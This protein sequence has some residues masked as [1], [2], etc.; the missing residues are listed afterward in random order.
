MRRRKQ[1]QIIKRKVNPPMP[2]RAMRST[3]AQ[4]ANTAFINGSHVSITFGPPLNAELKLLN[5]SKSSLSLL[6]IACS[7]QKTRS[8]LSCSAIQNQGDRSIVSV[9]GFGVSMLLCVPLPLYSLPHVSKCCMWLLGFDAYL[10]M[11]CLLSRHGVLVS[12]YICL[13]VYVCCIFFSISVVFGSQLSLQS[14]SKLSLQSLAEIIVFSVFATSRAWYPPSLRRK[15]LMM[16]WSLRVTM[17]KPETI[18]LT[19]SM[20][21]GNVKML[22]THAL[23]LVIRKSLVTMTRTL[24]RRVEII[25]NSTLL[26]N[27]KTTR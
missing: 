1:I 15:K 21:K 27:S 24:L 16:R 25:M 9:F 26:T 7:T 13:F 22:T 18:V 19:M 8:I 3:N 17:S 23:A 14:R 5:S 2:Y 12:V 11:C 4:H 10:G 6:Q 20:N